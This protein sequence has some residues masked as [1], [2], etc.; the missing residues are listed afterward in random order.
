MKAGLSA[1]SMIRIRKLAQG[2]MEKM[3]EMGDRAWK[4]GMEKAMPYQLRRD[5]SMYSW[6]AFSYG[7]EKYLVEFLPSQRQSFVNSSLRRITDCWSILVWA[8]I[9]GI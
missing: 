8:I 7:T 4:A 9:S 1:D 3:R 5:F 6:L 2:N